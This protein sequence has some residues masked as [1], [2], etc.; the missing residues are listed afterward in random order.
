VGRDALCGEVDGGVLGLD[1]GPGALVHGTGLGR[2]LSDT[3]HVARPCRICTHPDRQE[4]DRALIGGEGQLGIAARWRI[5]QSSVSRHKRLH[6]APVVANMMA[7]YETIDIERLRSWVNGLLEQNL[8][9]SLSAERRGDY[10]AQRGFLS[11]ARRAVEL[12]AK[13]AGLLDSGGPTI[14]VDARRQ[15]AVLANLTEEELRTALS[16]LAT[17]MELAAPVQV[18]EPVTR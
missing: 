7:K 13:L 6:L 16:G 14:S 17:R 9:G 1:D 15:V 2:R 4:I 11:E 3:N 5:A 8:L 10:G 12:Q 18:L